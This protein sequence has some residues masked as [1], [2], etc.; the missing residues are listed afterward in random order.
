[1][2]K[3]LCC[4][5]GWR[6][7]AAV[8]RAGH[9]LP[10]AHL[11][12]PGAA[13]QPNRAAAPAR[14]HGRGRLGSS[15]SAGWCQK[16]PTPPHGSEVS[17][18]A[19]TGVAAVSTRVAAGAGG[20]RIQLLVEQQRLRVPHRCQRGPR[21]HRLRSRPSSA[22]C[23]RGAPW[24]VGGPWAVPWGPPAAPAQALSPVPPR[25]L[26]SK[27]A[28]YYGDIASL[29]QEEPNEVHSCRIMLFSA[30]DLDARSPGWGTGARSPRL[31]PPSGWHSGARSP[32][33]GS[34]RGSVPYAAAVPKAGAPV[35][36]I[37]VTPC[38]TERE[39]LSTV[40][41]ANHP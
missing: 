34:A 7:W 3:W 10:A 32:A 2:V 1:M 22:V 28:S 5:W 24:A 27:C 18:A 23:R 37:P 11:P 17:A 16:P 39:V 30:E 8:G 38:P 14:T 25:L 4:R 36:L 21:R 31:H 35:V 9:P 20:D 33:L 19:W 40:G 26:P 12:G 15:G 41:S 13:A 29:A 6:W